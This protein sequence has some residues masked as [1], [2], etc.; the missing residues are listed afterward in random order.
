MS[1][2]NRYRNADLF[3]IIWEALQFDLNYEYE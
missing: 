1:E 3:Q 2:N